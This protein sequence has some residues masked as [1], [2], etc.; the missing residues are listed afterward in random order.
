MN[1][2]SMNRWLKSLKGTVAEGVKARASLRL[3][4]QLQPGVA[5]AAVAVADSGSESAFFRCLRLLP[6]QRPVSFPQSVGSL[7]DRAAMAAREG[8]LKD[9]TG[10]LVGLQRLHTESHRVAERLNTSG[11]ADSAGPFGWHPIVLLRL[12][13]GRLSTDDLSEPIA[14]CP[15]PMASVHPISH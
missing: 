11:F 1:L 14:L 13:L 10:C 7:R 6:V 3:D 4:G 12:E 5:I 15:H 2:R 9:L 8:R